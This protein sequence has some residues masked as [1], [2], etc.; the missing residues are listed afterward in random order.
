MPDTSSGYGA[1]GA[2]CPV[3]HAEAGV[4]FARGGALWRADLR[5]GEVAVALPADGRRWL[6][7]VIGP[8]GALHAVG[9]AAD[10]GF[11]YR[12][13]VSC[14]GPRCALGVAAR[15]RPVPASVGRVHGWDDEAGAFVATD[16]EGRLVEL[17]SEG[18]ALATGLPFRGRCGADLPD[19]ARVFVRGADQSAA[20][21]TQ[22]KP[23]QGSGPR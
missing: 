15:M 20:E 19:G 5:R 3:W 1:A 17:P 8:G 11:V 16:G 23:I 6:D 12:I 9:Q 2:G 18:P 14:D 10:G 13:A 21:A 4:L 7:P 22:R